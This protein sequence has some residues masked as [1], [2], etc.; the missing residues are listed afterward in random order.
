MQ[1]EIL[2]DIYKEGELRKDV[3][4]SS[5]EWGDPVKLPRGLGFRINFKTH[6]NLQFQIRDYES[7]RQTGNLV[8]RNA[9]GTFFISYLEYSYELSNMRNPLL[10]FKLVD[11][12]AP[13]AEISLLFL[14]R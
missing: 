6:G 9:G 11:S 10:Y 14:N 4:I 1:D 13:P 3:I 2:N 7:G 12:N 8:K 5:D